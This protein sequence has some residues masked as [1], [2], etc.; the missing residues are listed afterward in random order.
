MI[1]ASPPLWLYGG[2]RPVDE[3]AMKAAGLELQ[4]LGLIANPLLL[5]Y[6]RHPLMT[7]VPISLLLPPVFFFF[8]S[9]FVL[10]VPSAYGQPRT[11][12]LQGVQDCCHVR[13]AARTTHALLRYIR[14]HDQF[15]QSSLDLTCLLW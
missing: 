13:A 6:I 7:L 3:Y 2:W 5:P 8:F 11:D 12:R 10:L 1:S 9:L 14:T 4:G 15:D